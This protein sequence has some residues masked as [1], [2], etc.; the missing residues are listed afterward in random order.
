MEENEKIK[1][2]I[3]I[4]LNCEPEE[5]YKKYRKYKK[6]EQE[7]KELYEPFKEKLIGLHKS[8]PEMAKS[9][10]IGGVKLTYVSPSVRHTIDS[11]KLKEELPDIAEKFTKVTNVDASIK[12]EGVL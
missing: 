5:F 11:K 7:F 8:N 3:Q 12:I 2:E 4:L 10:I 1:E 6:A 9:A